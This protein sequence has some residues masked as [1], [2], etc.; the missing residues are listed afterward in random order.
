MIINYLI[1]ALGLLVL[2]KGADTMINSAS[3]IAAILKVPSFVIG[4]FIVAL[5]TSAP[6]AAIGIL[7]GL[8][9]NNTLSL[10]DVVGSSIVNIAVILGLT[11]MIFPIPVD[12]QVPKRVLPLSLFTQILL[13]IMMFTSYILSRLEAS[14]LLAGACL[15]VGYLT[16]EVKKM[17]E[18]EKPDTAF[19]GEVFDYIEDEEVLA[20]ALCDIPQEAIVLPEEKGS[21]SMKKQVPFFIIGLIGLVVGANFVVN[22]AVEI[23]H[24]LGWSEE[25]IGLTILAFGTSLPELVACLMAAIKKE[26]EIAL[27]NIVGSNIFNILFVLGA[28][29]LLNPISLAGPAFFFDA[30][31]M[32]GASVLLMV[33]IAVRGKIFKTAGFILLSY[34]VIYIA[35]KLSFLS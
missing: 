10:G 1:L 8:Q 25:F 31:M 9:G 5:G 4:L 29:G 32:I 35:I 3:R 23:A 7:S 2:I 15:F 16:F 11:A 12:S 20:E 28:S 6:E 21:E 34:Y 26:E 13:V 19:E 14:I 33:L 18:K 30:F 27:G 17:S 22:S 24:T